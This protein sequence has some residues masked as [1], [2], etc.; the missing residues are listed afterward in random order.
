MQRTM[1][2]QVGSFWCSSTAKISTLLWK[3][4]E[5]LNA[6]VNENIHDKYASFLPKRVRGHLSAT[7]TFSAASSES[8]PDAF[9][10][11]Q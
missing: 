10:L 8:L 5:A 11:V 4:S 2:D 1:L 7:L 6:R 3:T 9:V